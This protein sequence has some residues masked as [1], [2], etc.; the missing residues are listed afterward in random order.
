[1]KKWMYLCLALLL[2][3]AVL[4]YVAADVNEGH[5]PGYVAEEG[6]GEHH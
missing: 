4:L 1:M 5:G 6:E 3:A 2:S